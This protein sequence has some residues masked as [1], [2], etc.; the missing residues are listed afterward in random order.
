[1]SCTPTGIP[2]TDITGTVDIHAP[3]GYRLLHMQ[4]DSN[5][6]VPVINGTFTVELTLP[7]IQGRVLRARPVLPDV[8]VIEGDAEERTDGM[9]AVRTWT[10]T[11]APDDLLGRAIG[12][13]GLLGTTTNVDVGLDTIIDDLKWVIEGGFELTNDQWSITTF[14]FWGKLE[15]E[16]KTQGLLGERDTTLSLEEALLDVA[17]LYRIGEWPLGNSETATWNLDLGPGLRYWHVDVEVDTKGALGIDPDLS[18]VDD[19]VDPLIVG[20]LGLRPVV[21]R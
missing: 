11:C 4:A 6:P 21:D 14:G 12:V 2:L 5:Q 9:K 1:M 7:I 18:S 13:R 20:R 16:S 10:M 19:W 17:L 8:C 15:T 3:K